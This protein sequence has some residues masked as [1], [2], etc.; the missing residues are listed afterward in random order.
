M[1]IGNIGHPASLIAA[2]RVIACRCAGIHH[3]N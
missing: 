3:D 2:I 1:K